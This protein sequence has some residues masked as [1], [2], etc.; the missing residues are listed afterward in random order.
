MFKGKDSKEDVQQ[1]KP[2]KV[3]I[4]S[5]QAVKGVNNYK[6]LISYLEFTAIDQK[7]KV[8]MS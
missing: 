7:K 4:F 2:A 8:E 1:D 5:L 3:S 6:S